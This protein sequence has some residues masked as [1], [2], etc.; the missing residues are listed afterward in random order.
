[1]AADP[2][3]KPNS[4]RREGDGL[5]IEWND[6]VRT[7]ITW[8]DLRKNCPCATCQETHGKPENP[9]KILSPQELAVGAPEP[10]SIQTRGSYAYQVY[11][12]DGHDTGIYSLEYLR[13]ISKPAEQAGH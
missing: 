5:L 6:G 12:N 13:E 2:A 4:L 10:R 1:M 9:F 11:W 7:F 3:L 8:R